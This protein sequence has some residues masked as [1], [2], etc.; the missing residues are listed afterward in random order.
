MEDLV[1]LD[2]DIIIDHLKGK[3]PGVSV[4]ET[5]VTKMTPCTTYVTRFELLCGAR[6]SREIKIIHDC[7]LGLTFLSFDEA[8]SRQ[9]AQV[10]RELKAQ[11]KL[12][13]I[14]DIMI[15]GTVLA[16]DMRIATKNMKDFSRIKGIR[17]YKK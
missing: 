15:A 11:G 10:Y 3:G 12:I 9:A 4:F 8:A 16:N 13:G 2:T 17:I 6:N 1:C 7:L 5:V 14:G